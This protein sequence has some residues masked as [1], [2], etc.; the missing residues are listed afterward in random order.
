MPLPL[1]RRTAERIL[2]V[3]LLAGLIA[4]T[5]ALRQAR[6]DAREAWD[7]VARMEAE[8][9]AALADVRRSIRDLPPPEVGGAPA[10]PPAPS[11]AEP[12]SDR[13]VLGLPLD[14]PERPKLTGRERF[15]EVRSRLAEFNRTG[16]LPLDNLYEAMDRIALEEGWDDATYDDVT[17]V[18]EQSMDIFGDTWLD[19]REGRLTLPQARQRLVRTR[20]D[21]VN[22]LQTRLGPDEFARVR[23]SLV[24]EA[25]AMRGG[26][27]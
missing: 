5:W 3:G 14:E 4:Q 11:Q 17:L 8:R 1:T 20:E 6:G 12:D 2:A 21:A 13:Q 7:E 19:L 10:P 9:E 23:A 22:A 25:R 15:Q 24:E 27:R 16:E 18:F 26:R